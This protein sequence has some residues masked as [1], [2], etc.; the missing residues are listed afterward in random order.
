MFENN[1]SEI[2]KNIQKDIERWATLPLDFSARIRTVKMNIVPK[3]LYLFQALPKQIYSLGQDD[4]L[5]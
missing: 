1:Y 2:E 4:F 3:L 5:D